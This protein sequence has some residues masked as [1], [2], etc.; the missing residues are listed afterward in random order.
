[1]KLLKKATNLLLVLL[2]SFTM[3]PLTACNP[4]SD[5]AEAVK[6]MNVSLNP[7]VEFILDKDDKVISV[8]ALNEE[9]NLII[10]ADAFKKVEGKT[11]EEGAE[12]FVQVAEETGFLVKGRVGTGDNQIEIS[13]SGDTEDAE[14]LFN[15]VKGKVE[16][17]FNKH[18]IT[19]SISKI[20]EVTKEQ[21]QA[22]LG[23]IAPYLDAAKIQAMEYKELL[24]EIHASRKETRDIYSQELKE[25]Y[26]E[27]KEFIFKKAELEF[28]KSKVGAL[29]EGAISALIAS[30]ETAVTALEEARKAYFIDENSVYQ[31]ALQAFR[32]KKAEFLKFKNYVASLEESEV[33]QE[34]LDELNLINLALENAKTAL[35]EVKDQAEEVLD[36]LEDDVDNAYEAIIDAVEVILGD[37]DDMIEDDFDDM[38]DDD[39]EDWDEDFMD[40]HEHHKNHAKHKWDSMR[41]NLKEGFHREDD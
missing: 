23:E 21:L 3:I 2:L 25:A 30:Y 26:Y 24:K 22:L 7:Q 11:A 29:G 28:L 1:M 36:K 37:I 6:V 35:E 19:A 38:F 4:A 32:E 8:N 5:S 33:T 16:G 9:G 41:E 31:V 17:Y 13:F 40:R 34:I 14:K 15:K 27:A 20:A 12:L 10:T 39:H 18:D